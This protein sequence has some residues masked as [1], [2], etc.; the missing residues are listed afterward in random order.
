MDHPFAGGV[1]TL[2]KSTLFPGQWAQQEIVPGRVLSVS[3]H[4]PDFPVDIVNIHIE[5]GHYE[6]STRLT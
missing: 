5:H 2:I 6:G 1:L 4:H 3:C